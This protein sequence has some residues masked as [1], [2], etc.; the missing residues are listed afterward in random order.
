MMLCYYDRLALPSSSV[1][2]F[3]CSCDG[4]FSSVILLFLLSFPAPREERELGRTKQKRI[5]SPWILDCSLDLL[6]VGGRADDGSG[7]GPARGRGHDGVASNEP[8]PELA[9][10]SFERGRG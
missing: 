3:L 6:T 4:C 8:E 1:S 2:V 7:F 5:S 10:E 9:C